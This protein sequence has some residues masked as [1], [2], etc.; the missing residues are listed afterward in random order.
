MAEMQLG[1]YLLCYFLL[2]VAPL[3]TCDF[4]TLH[5]QRTP[6]NEHAVKLDRIGIVCGDVLKMPSFYL[7]GGS[8]DGGPLDDIESSWRRAEGGF[9][10]IFF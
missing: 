4:Q 8:R 7:A 9:E 5:L 1:I 6:V 10:E 2:A 3:V